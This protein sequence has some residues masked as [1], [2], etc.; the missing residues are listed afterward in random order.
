MIDPQYQ[1]CAIIDVT[2]ACGRACSNCTRMVGHGPTYTMD[3]LQ[4]EQA[5]AAVADFPA[6]SPPSEVSDV[7]LVG[8]MGG[9]PLLHPEFNELCRVFARQ[10]P[11]RDHR[12][13]W[14]GLNWQRTQHADIIR[15]VFNEKYIHNNRHDLQHSKH[16]PILVASRDAISD[17]DQ[18][19]EVIDNCWLQKTWCGTINPK[20]HF[21]CE[22]A[23][24]FD[25]VSKGP[26]GLPVEPEC[27][28]RP[29]G[30]FQDQIDRWCQRCGIALNLEG[31]LDH[32]EVDDISE[33]NLELLRNSPRV[34][35]GKFVQYRKGE[36]RP[37]AQEPW[38]YRVGKPKQETA[39]ALSGKVAVVTLAT[40]DYWRGARV[41]FR[42]LLKH[43]MPESVTRIVLSN[44]RKEPDFAHRQPIQQDY[45]WIKTKRGQFA[46]TALKFAALTLDFERIILIDS[47][48]M[49]IQPCGLLW[50]EHLNAL[51]FY[52]VRDTAAIQYYPEE[53]ERIGLE[54]T[55]IFN[56]GVMVYNRDRKPDFHD[57]LLDRIR[58]GKCESYDGGDQGYFN[59]FFQGIG[60]EVGYLPCGYNYPPDP[61]WAKLPPHARY[62]YHFAGGQ[63]PWHR[64]Y[65]GN[66]EC[67]EY[68]KQWKEIAA[69]E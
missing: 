16:S 15:E 27:W 37:T 63:Q 48:I 8:I 31:R 61:Y 23:A 32:E 54:E 12:G 1:W 19:A 52:A 41:L 9:E 3:V 29:I 53:I 47:D 57:R 6:E 60:Q 22:V 10:I 51:P 36:R 55:L 28:R 24:A 65:S 45:R 40:G 64:R 4:F 18:R 46:K 56:A 34:R 30:D 20:G 42:S 66:A 50:S 49:C 39:P 14:T 26:G 33:S 7:K 21:F 35:A 69:S 68:V 11:N 5:L 25:W 67:Q 2:N 38:Q 58:S 44:D 43:G 62:L 17:P 59:S 13:L